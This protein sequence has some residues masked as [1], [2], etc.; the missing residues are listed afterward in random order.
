MTTLSNIK[1]TKIQILKNSEL[2]KG[3]GVPGGPFINKCPTCDKRK[4]VPP[5]HENW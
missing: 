2:I 5:P 1:S 4:P 3:G